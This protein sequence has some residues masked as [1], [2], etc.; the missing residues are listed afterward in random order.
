VNAQIWRTERLKI[1]VIRG[2]SQI[3]NLDPKFSFGPQISS[4]GPKSESSLFANS[5]AAFFLW[6]QNSAMQGDDRE[7]VIFGQC[8]YESSLV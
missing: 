2:D 3:G 7:E 6:T 4:R 5:V 8:E 1:K